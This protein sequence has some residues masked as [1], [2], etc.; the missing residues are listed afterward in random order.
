MIPESIIFLRLAVHVPNLYV[1]KKTRACSV[2]AR[3]ATETTADRPGIFT[4]KHTVEF[5]T[6]TQH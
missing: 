1:C 4:A 2:Q 3:D 6:V 5:Q